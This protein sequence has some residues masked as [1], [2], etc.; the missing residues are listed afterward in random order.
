MSL[1]DA[2][3]D[4]GPFHFSYCDYDAGNDVAY[5]SVEAPRAAIAWESPEGHLVRLDPDT[6]ELV[7]VTFLGAKRCLEAGGLRITFPDF[8][9]T[10]DPSRSGPRKPTE[11]PR[12]SLASVC[13]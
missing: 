13:V 4:I 10:P 5:L 8:L 7:G 1:P 12:R 2:T 6:D 11:V 9:L 3:V